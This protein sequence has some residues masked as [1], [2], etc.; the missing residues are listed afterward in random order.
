LSEQPS[1]QRIRRIEEL[2]D[3][4]EKSGDAET[5]ID[6]RQLV[7]AMMDFHGAAVDRMMEIIAEESPGEPPVFETFAR[8]E[9]VSSLLLLYGLHP[10]D[11]ETRVE[12]ALDK[13]RPVLRAQSGNVNLIRIEG[14]EVYLKFDG[15]PAAHLKATIEEEIYRTAA[16]VTAIHLEGFDSLHASNGLIQVSL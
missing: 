15:K 13:A 1:Q 11:L 5:R 12:Q 8:D 9:L 2:I 7:Q 10:V 14:G 16:D 6:V 3:K 4:F